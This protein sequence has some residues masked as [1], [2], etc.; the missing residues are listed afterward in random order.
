M[1]IRSAVSVLLMVCISYVRLTTATVSGVYRDNGVDRTERTAEFSGRDKREMQHEILT[2]LGL[3][4]RPKPAGHSTTDYS[5]PRFMLNLYNSITSDGGIVDD[6]N[7]PQFPRNVTIENEIEPTEGSDV[8]MSFVNHA[9]KIKHLRRQRD[10]TFYFDFSEITPKETVARAELRLYK[11][12][13]GKWKKHK[14]QVQIY[15]IQQGDNPENY[16]IVTESNLTVRANYQGWLTFNLTNAAS[17]WTYSPTTN[18]GLFMKIIFLKKNRDVKPEKFGIVGRKGPEYKQ[19]FM[20]GYFRSTPELH[21]R[22]TRAAVR[23]RMKESAYANDDEEEQYSY[24]KALRRTPRRAPRQWPCQRR[25]LYMKFRDL[26]WQN[27]IIAPDGFK[28]FYCDGECS[29][30][31]G[32]HMNATNHAIIQTL[33]HLMTPYK[34]PSPGCAPTKLGSQS[35][36]YFDHNYNVVLK[37]F[38]DMIVKSCGCH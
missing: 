33:V 13:A 3:H 1:E 11:E 14:F 24:T 30:P 6:G 38:P 31:L 12:K 32:A 28:A 7:R 29:F 34:A 20:V 9:K 4:H 15:M 5:A 17:H 22:K 10:R 2:L 35:V 19:P 26:G 27:W 25:T 16:Q 8:I 23:R 36:L 37:R 21:V 18:M